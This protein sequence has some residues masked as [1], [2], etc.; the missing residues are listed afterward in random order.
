MP[1]DALSARVL[2]LLLLLLRAGGSSFPGSESSS[3]YPR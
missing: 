3:L 1:A 2:L